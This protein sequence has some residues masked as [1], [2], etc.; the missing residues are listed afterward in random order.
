MK[1]TTF[2]C[3]GCQYID[4]NDV[5]LCVGK[6][7]RNISGLVVHGRSSFD[8]DVIAHPKWGV[9]DCYFIWH[10]CDNWVVQNWDTGIERKR[11]PF[12]RY[13]N[14]MER[15]TMTVRSTSKRFSASS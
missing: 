13:P 10:N 15:A 1:L 7:P 14:P 4:S 12:L 5:A 2:T 3:K 6:E 9:I 8:V 11:T